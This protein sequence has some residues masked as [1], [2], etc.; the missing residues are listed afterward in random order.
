MLPADVR[1][2][3]HMLALATCLG[4]ANLTST[5]WYLE[6]TPVLLRGIAEAVERAHANG[7]H[8]D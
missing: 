4:H 1:P 3:R 6:A 2:G 8:N 7:G 5:Y